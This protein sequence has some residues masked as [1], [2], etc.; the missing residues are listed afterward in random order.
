MGVQSTMTIGDKQG[1]AAVTVAS[2]AATF[3]STF[4]VRIV[5][6]LPAADLHRLA[7]IQRAVQICI[8]YARDNNLYTGGASIYVV[9]TLSGGKVAIRTGAVASA[10]VTNDVGIMVNNFE[11]AK[12]ARNI[13]DN[14]HKQLLDW[15]N[16]QDRLAA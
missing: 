3:P 2:G 14:A 9:T 4:Q 6:I 15:M 16:E 8:D 5:S 10:V 1:S 7:D 13:M 12:G 11:S